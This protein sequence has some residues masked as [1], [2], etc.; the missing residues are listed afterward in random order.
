M[1]ELC[2]KDHWELI[3]QIMDDLK[4]YQLVVLYN[5]LNPINHQIIVL[6][7]QFFYRFGFQ[8]YEIMCFVLGIIGF[9]KF[10]FVGIVLV[11]FGGLMQDVGIEV[12]K[13]F[14]VIKR[15]GLVFFYFEQKFFVDLI[16]IVIIFSLQKLDFI[17]FELEVEFAVEL[18]S[19]DN[20]QYF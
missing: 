6:L 2:Q 10:G 17:A 14:D 13:Q 7:R 20:L 19:F 11:R 18:L 3:I 1:Q 5:F 16:D 12:Q 9:G 15:F 4:D 8:L